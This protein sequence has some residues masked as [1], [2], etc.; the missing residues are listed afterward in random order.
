MVYN[1]KHK[2]LCVHSLQVLSPTRTHGRLFASPTHWCPIP[3]WVQQ[4]LLMSRAALKSDSTPPHRNPC[5]NEEGRVEHR[6]R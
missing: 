5:L 6:W 2:M 4:W 3:R 1:Q